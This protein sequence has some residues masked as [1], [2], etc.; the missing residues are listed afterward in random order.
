MAPPAKPFWCYKYL[1]I[2]QKKKVYVELGW[3]PGIVFPYFAR[4]QNIEPQNKAPVG[5]THQKNINQVTK[6]TSLKE[7][8]SILGGLHFPNPLASSHPLKLLDLL[9]ANRLD[10][11][12]GHSGCSAF[13][14]GLH[15]RQGS[16]FFLK[17]SLGHQSWFGQ[18][19][20][21]KTQHC[22]RNIPPTA[23]VSTSDTPWHIIYIIWMHVALTWSIQYRVEQFHWQKKTP[24]SWTCFAK[25][26]SRQN[27]PHMVT[28]YIRLL[29]SS[30][31]AVWMKTFSQKQNGA[32]SK[33]TN[34]QFRTFK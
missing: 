18:E 19:I 9:I 23:T 5:K 33:S 14:Q 10:G 26:C 29:N 30:S 16:W 20:C 15:C 25:V 24:K 32:L 11:S 6:G 31:K 27:P 2:A 22:L 3:W 34:V 21:R 13:Q 28:P 7:F 1:Q 4:K 12:L 8:P 17:K